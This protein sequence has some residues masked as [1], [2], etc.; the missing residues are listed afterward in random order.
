MLMRGKVSFS[1]LEG[2]RDFYIFQDFQEESQGEG[3]LLLRLQ[4]AVAWGS[5]P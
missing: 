2:L 5:A 3:K 4:L 1:L